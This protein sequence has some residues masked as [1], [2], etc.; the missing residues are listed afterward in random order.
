M[1]TTTNPRTAVES[2]TALGPTATDDVASIASLASTAFATIQKSSRLWRA[3]LLDALADALEANRAELVATAEAETALG[4]PRLTGELTRSVFQFRLFGEALRD[5]GY[6]DAAIDHAGPTPMGPGPDVRRMLI[7]IGPVAVF[8]SSNFPFAFSVAGG[9]TA[10]ALAAGCP[11]VLKA[12]GSHPLVSLASFTVLNNAAV[13]YGAPAG[14]LGIVYGTAAG[15]ALVA[16]PNIKAVGFTGSLSGGQA[17]MDIVSGREEPIPFYGELSSINPLIITPAAAAARTAAIAEGLFTSFT[18]SSGQLCT[19]PGI[20]FVP[21]TNAGRVLVEGIIDRVNAAT[22]N[23]LLNAR[24]FESFGEIESR[25]ESVGRAAV[26]AV[27]TVSGDGFQVAPRLLTIDASDLTAA[28]SEEAFGPL[29]VVAWYDDL[30]D[31]DRAFGVIPNSLTATIH[32][33]P[34]DDE[35]VASL[36][37]TVS[38]RAGRLVFNGYPTGVRVSWAQ[39][40]GGPWPA[41]NSLHTSVGVTAVRRFLRPFV[42]Q[43]A[44]ETLLPTELRDADTS[45]PRRVDGVLTLAG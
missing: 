24:I 19:K 36:V 5:G 15:A 29:L 43:D 26:S 31:V 7:P 11:V 45:V 38:P 33:E 14:T 13:A 34:G 23:P 22:S 16:D 35:L 21:R 44:P 27:G 41:T 39:H 1:I 20:A 10:S 3:G 2:D 37:E 12:H 28:T 42:W 6:L 32:S 9:D 40:H 30:L 25:I 8:G 4:L 18:A 17:L